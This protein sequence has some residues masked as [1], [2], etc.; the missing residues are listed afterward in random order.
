MVTHSTDGQPDSIL[1]TEELIQFIEG[2]IVN[3][4]QL[5][6]IQIKQLNKFNQTS[7]VNQD[8][9]KLYKINVD[10]TSNMNLKPIDKERGYNIS[11]Q[12]DVYMAKAF[13]IQFMIRKYSQNKLHISI[14]NQDLF[15]L[16]N[17]AWQISNATND[18]AGIKEIV[19]FLNNPPQGI[20]GGLMN[21]E[22]KHIIKIIMI[23]IIISI[24]IYFCNL[25]QKKYYPIY[26]S[27]G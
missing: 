5:D 24:I 23:I 16:G 25:V 7:Q 3:T 2:K 26:K 14:G 13:G 6:A 17:K 12:F 27:Y 20:Y 10:T 18:I 9:T 15:T 21:L 22:A 8:E 1:P 4:L 11:L 19:P